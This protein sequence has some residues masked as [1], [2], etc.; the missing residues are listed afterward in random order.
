MNPGQLVSSFSFGEFG[1]YDR[2][3]AAP[4]STQKC[5]YRIFC[6]ACAI[7]GA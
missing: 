3:E 1:S 4:H 2:T 5:R 7:A 6:I